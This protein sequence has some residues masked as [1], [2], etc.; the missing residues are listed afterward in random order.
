MSNRLSFPGI[1]MFVLLGM[2]L[3]LSGAAP[4][5]EFISISL[6]TMNVK[7]DL[8][9]YK[10]VLDESKAGFLLLDADVVNKKALLLLY[11]ESNKQTY[12]GWVDEAMFVNSAPA[13]K[14]RSG[15]KLLKVTENSATFEIRFAR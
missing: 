7:L 6:Y 2:S 5:E 9:Q 8:R 4:R 14:G 13:L 12:C 3:P 11:D 10:N 1:L 15:L